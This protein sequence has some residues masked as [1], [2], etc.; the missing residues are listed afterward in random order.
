MH[1]LASILETNH[2]VMLKTHRDV[3][4]ADAL[5]PKRHIVSS[6]P[7]IAS[8]QAE[9]RLYSIETIHVYINCAKWGKIKITSLGMLPYHIPVQCFL[10]LQS[11]SGLAWQRRI[12]WFRLVER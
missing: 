9:L 6:N 12:N 2:D 7:T 4:A 11:E 1:R 5:V 10:Q 3:K 8:I